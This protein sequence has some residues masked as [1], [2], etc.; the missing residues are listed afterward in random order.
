MEELE[1]WLKENP[2]N[3]WVL[4]IGVDALGKY[5]VSIWQAQGITA[6]GNADTIQSAI[7]TAIAEFR[8]NNQ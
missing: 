3:R 7:T 1:K 4:G 2:K 6:M 8:K 5:T